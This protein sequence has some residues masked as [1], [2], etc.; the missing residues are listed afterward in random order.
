MRQ[1]LLS[2]SPSSFHALVYDES[3]REEGSGQEQ[4]DENRSELL[5]QFFGIFVLSGKLIA[6]CSKISGTWRFREAVRS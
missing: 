2:R 5:I 4:E 3:N 1:A 6:L